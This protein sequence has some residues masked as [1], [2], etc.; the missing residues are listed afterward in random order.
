MASH[1]WHGFA[2]MSVVKDADP[3]VIARGEGAYL[4]DTSGRR[5]LDGSAGLWFCN[6]GHGRTALADAA[7]KQMST[8]ASYSTFGDYS[9][10]PIEELA[11]R[12]AALSPTDGASVFFTSGGSDSNDSMIKLVRRYWIELGQPQRRVIVSR[13]LSYHGGH[14]GSTGLGGIPGDYEGYGELIRDTAR[15]PWESAEALEELVQRLGADRIAAFVLEPIIAAGGVYF[16][17]EG[18]LRR[19]AEICRRHGIILVADEVVTGFGRAGDWFASIRFGLQPDIIVCAKGLTS[20]YTPLGALIVGDRVA[21]P[22][23]DGRA[24]AFNHGYT[25]SGHPVGAAVALANLDI[26]EREQLATHVRELA[27]QLPSL[28]AEV[29]A[30]PVVKE[31]RTGPA[32]MAAVVFEDDALAAQPSLPGEVA[33]AM[34]GFGVLTRSLVG[35]ELQFSP[36]L[37]VERQQVEGYVAAALGSIQAAT[38]HTALAS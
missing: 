16:P 30:A 19:I 8:L 17:P 10:A 26:I 12:L 14:M 37:V 27:P 5:Y 22:F 24:G 4:F 2:D 6:V 13:E 34:R 33:A 21:A 35:G 18:Y 29:A 11:D 3:F 28:F 38:R 23:Y 31:V 20:G 9:N 15:I 25:Y 36:P 1:F 32:L 7:R